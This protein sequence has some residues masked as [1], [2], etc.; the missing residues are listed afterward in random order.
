MWAV[1]QG[2]ELVDLHLWIEASAAGSQDALDAS[3]GAPSNLGHVRAR[4]WRQRVKD[5]RG[6]LR[7]SHVDTVEGQYMDMDVQTHCAVRSLNGCDRTL[8]VTAMLPSPSKR[9]ALCRSER[10]TSSTNAPTTSAHSLRS[11]PSSA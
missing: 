1:E 7:R 9:L 10:R 4:R 5:E 8:C 3:S 6:A 11:Y 2:Q